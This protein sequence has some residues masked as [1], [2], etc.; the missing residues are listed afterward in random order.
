MEKTR[1]DSTCFQ[2]RF[3]RI[4]LK[5]SRADGWGGGPHSFDKSGEIGGGEG[6]ARTYVR[7]T[8][9][10]PHIVPCN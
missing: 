5:R 9:P 1:M 10:L 4:D 3:R 7:T 2:P 6:N 8:P